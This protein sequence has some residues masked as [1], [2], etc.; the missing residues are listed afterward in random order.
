MSHIQSNAALVVQD[1]LRTIGKRHLEKYGTTTLF[2]EDFMDDGS[3]I[4]LKVSIDIESGTAVI[5]F[6]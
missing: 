3:P 6:T 1:L 2:A 5:D 4:R